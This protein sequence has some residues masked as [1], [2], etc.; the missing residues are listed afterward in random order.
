M[1]RIRQAVQRFAAA[2]RLHSQRTAAAQHIQAVVRGWLARR[3]ANGLRSTRAQ[4]AAVD[5]SRRQAAVDIIA[6][7]A[8]TFR[9]RARF[10]RLR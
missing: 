8:L 3:L 7:W 2:A 6:C 1:L 10:L 5:A 9:D 4:A